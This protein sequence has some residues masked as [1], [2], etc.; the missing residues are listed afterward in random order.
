[1]IPACLIG[2]ATGLRST[3]GLAALSWAARDGALTGAAAP[4]SRPWVRIATL[5]GAAGEF[6]ADKSPSTANRLSAAGLAPR[7]LLGALTGATLSDPR[8]RTRN[9]PPA[10]GAAAGAA[11]SLLAAFAGQRWRTTDRHGVSTAPVA[12][13][14]EDLAA[15]T[16]ATAACALA[17]RARRRR[18]PEETAPG[19]DDAGQEAGAKS[20]RAML[21]G[22]RNS[23]M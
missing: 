4:L 17:I 14:T 23:R 8:T 22:S 18:T 15:A 12:A 1:M 16:L 11:A 3:W 10:L 7:L 6:V 19:R 13:A 21:S 2:A 9:A 5:A 20:S